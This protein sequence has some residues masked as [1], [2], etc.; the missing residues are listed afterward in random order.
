MKYI[1]SGKD[2]SKIGGELEIFNSK[3]EAGA[4]LRSQ[5]YGADNRDGESNE[6]LFEIATRATYRNPAPYWRAEEV[7]DE[8]AASRMAELYDMVVAP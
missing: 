7:A 2:H 1:V 4:Y 8:D 3:S 5:G 6:E